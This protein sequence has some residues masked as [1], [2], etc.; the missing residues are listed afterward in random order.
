VPR[1]DRDYSM[2]ER[3]ISGFKADKCSD[4]KTRQGQRSPPS[5]VAANESQRRDAQLRLLARR[6]KHAAATCS[7][8][9]NSAFPMATISVVG[10]CRPERPPK[11]A[12]QIPR[13]LPEV[14]SHISLE[15]RG[16]ESPLRTRE[17]TTTCLT[18]ILQGYGNSPP[19][20]ASYR[21]IGEPLG[22]ARVQQSAGA[23]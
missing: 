18:H 13:A 14:A 17:S 16:S 19:G 12:Q 9:A 11:C 5:D 3:K 6:D 10:T 1:R 21:L 22:Q 15:H 7:R 8:A 4:A 20:W 23:F 2:A